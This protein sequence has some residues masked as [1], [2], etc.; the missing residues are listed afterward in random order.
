MRY[1]AAL[2]L[3]L[4]A[5]MPVAGFAAPAPDQE[6]FDKAA[7][8]GLFEV[9]SSEVA[10]KRASDPALKSFAQMMVS[11]HGAANGKLKALAAKKNVKLPQGLDKEHQ[12]NLDKLAAAKNGRA[13]DETY[14]DLMEDGHDQA[15]ELFETASKDAKDPDVRAFAAETLPTLKHHSEAAERLDKRDVAP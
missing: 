14:A 9:K 13:F 3:L 7:V 15:V 5:A 12:K 10:L 4:A 11:D 8:A 6:F 2:S 1:L